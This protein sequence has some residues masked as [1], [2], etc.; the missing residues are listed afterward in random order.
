MSVRNIDPEMHEILVELAR[1]GVPPNLVFELYTAVKALRRIA[2][3][4]INPD[5]VAQQALEMIE[6]P[7]ISVEWRDD[8]DPSDLKAR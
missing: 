2:N 7:D 3:G 5:I 1:A 4:V 6:D 8:D